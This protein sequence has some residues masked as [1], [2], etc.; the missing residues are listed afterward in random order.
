MAAA[1]ASSGNTKLSG[2]EGL[3]IDLDGV[4]SIG[5]ALVQGPAEAS[6]LDQGGGDTRAQGLDD[7][8]HP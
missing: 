3:L 8:D 6:E 1:P 2:I 7:R 5:G 4:V